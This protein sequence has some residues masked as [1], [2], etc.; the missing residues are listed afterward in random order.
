MN[1]DYV[2]VRVKPEL[3]EAFKAATRILCG[4]GVLREAG[5]LAQAY[6]T[7]AGRDRASARR[8]EPFLR[9]LREHGVTG[10]VFATACYPQAD[11]QGPPTT[12]TVGR[13]SSEKANEWYPA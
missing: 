10:I 5:A 7:R 11:G 2:H 4:A 13:W 6:G 8:S 9:L 1:M 12:E 3:V